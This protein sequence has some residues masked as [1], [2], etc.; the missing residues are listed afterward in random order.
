METS[1]KNNLILG[2]V[3]NYEYDVL[4]PFINTLKKTGY[5]GDI[6]FF[7]ADLSEKT[8]KKL[9]GTGVMLIP[10]TDTFPY[11]PEPFAQ[12]MPLWAKGRAIQVYCLRYLLAQAYLTERTEQ[13]Q[14]VM[15]TDTRDV[16]FQ[17]DPFDFNIDAR[18]CC[19]EEKEG[20]T[21]GDS[22]INAEWIESAF[23]PE[24][25]EK[26]SHRPIICSGITIGSVS[27]VL[28]YLGTFVRTLSEKHIP[29]DLRGIDQGVHNYLV[30]EQLL[31]DAVL[32]KN[33]GGPVLTL[34]LEDSIALDAKG[35]IQNASGIVPNIVHQYD[36]HWHIA[37]RYYSFG[38][39]L[40][41]YAAHARG[42]ISIGIRSHAPRLYRAGIAT[43]HPTRMYYKIVLQIKALY[44]SL[45]RLFGSF[46]LIDNFGITMRVY[47]FDK[48]PIKK[49]LTRENYKEEFAVYNQYARGTVI[50]VG[51]HIGLHAVYLSRVA[52]RVFTFEPVPQN[53]TKLQETLQLNHTRNVVPINAAAGEAPGR[54]TMQLFSDSMSAWHSFYIPHTDAARPIAT[55]EVEVS[56]LD[57]LAEKFDLNFIEFVK[58][59]VEGHE[60][61]V[62]HGARAL[63]SAHRIG[64]LSFEVTAMHAWHVQEIFS[65]LYS[66]GYH[67]TEEY[68]PSFTV[69]NYYAVLPD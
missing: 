42:I 56:T 44:Y 52:E 25:R 55:Q 61:A 47:P 64:A 48:T 58:I 21:I 51:G 3:M 7:C 6:V 65:L 11:L 26:L 66:H 2:T 17:K 35:N 38:F 13:Y 30:H 43:L 40:K 39:I 36:R 23:G 15:L 8:E 4:A 9:R 18:L 19:F 28:S 50:D 67:I 49:L 22:P 32:F 59:D 33:S 45:L 62:L 27:A 60:L 20:T 10:F 54:A 46:I 63:L 31:P 1:Q 34:G 37:K 41:H 12:H 69:H 57:A 53:F 5:A 68:N 29:M 14:N 24:E 16:I